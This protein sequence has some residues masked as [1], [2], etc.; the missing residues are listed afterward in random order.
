MFCAIPGHKEPGMVGDLM[1]GA[2]GDHAE[3]VVNTDR[4]LAENDAWTR[5]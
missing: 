2:M 5:R 3:K 1:V 4:M